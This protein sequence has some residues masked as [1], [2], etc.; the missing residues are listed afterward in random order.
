MVVLLYTWFDLLFGIGEQVGPRVFNFVNLTIRP[1]HP[2][3]FAGQLQPAHVGLPK[4]RKSCGNY[5]IRIHE[6]TRLYQDEIIDWYFPLIRC[7][8]LWLDGF[9]PTDIRSGS[10]FDSVSTKFNIANR[11]PFLQ[12]WPLRISWHADPCKN[13]FE[14]AKKVGRYKNYSFP[15][16]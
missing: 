15:P 9:Q 6:M 14:V 2:T 12:P 16:R 8:N 13:R 4:Y 11:G 3:L 7:R 10:V 1:P 5:R